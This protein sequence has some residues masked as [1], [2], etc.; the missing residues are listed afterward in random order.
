MLNRNRTKICSTSGNGGLEKQ[1]EIKLLAKAGGIW[2]VEDVGRGEEKKKV[3]G[4]S[5]FKKRKKEKQEVLQVRAKVTEC[6][7][8]KQCRLRGKQE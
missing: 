7:K 1:L 2:M 4:E 5:R 8:E 6:G 3:V